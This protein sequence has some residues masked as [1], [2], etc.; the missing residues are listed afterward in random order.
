ME[1]KI[2]CI[3]KI[4]NKINDCFYIGSTSD[5]KNRKRKHFNDLKNNKHSN[6]HLQNAYNLYGKDNFEIIIIEHIQDN[7]ILIER[8]QYWIDKYDAINSG[9][10]L[11]PNAGST[12]GAKW[13]EESRANI[14]K[15]RKGRYS[16]IKNPMYG[17]NGANSPV[18]KKIQC[19]E[20]EE[21]F[22]CMLDIE[23]NLHIDSSS[24]CKCCRGQRKTA[25]GYHWKYIG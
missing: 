13:S 25:G 20:T 3:Y 24:V 4:K 2:S 18:A 15:N 21:I 16:G 7:S 11:A 9:Y 23:R 1:E 22:E 14:S 10:N 5:F 17:I 6:R 8:E 12:L 19:I